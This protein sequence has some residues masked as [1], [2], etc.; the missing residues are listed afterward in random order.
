[1]KKS[2][3]FGDWRFF[4]WFFL[5]GTGESPPYCDKITVLYGC[6]FGVKKLG[7]G[8]T[9]G[10]HPHWD[11]IPTFTK[12]NFWLLPYSPLKKKDIATNLR[13]DL[14]KPSCKKCFLSGI[15]DSSAATWN[16]FQPKHVIDL[17]SVIFVLLCKLFMKFNV[18]LKNP[19][20]IS[21]D[22]KF[23]SKFTGLLL[24]VSSTSLASPAVLQTTAMAA[25]ICWWTSNIQIASGQRYII[26][27]VL[28]HWSHP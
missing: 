17:K 25:G 11:K 24:T 20:D 16:H 22:Y 5:V 13:F 28:F 2:H 1:M 18:V 23:T 26:Q 9:P 19:T 6:G 12:K 10:P 8:Q 15:A 27:G 3:S 14:G 4:M 21:F 7:L